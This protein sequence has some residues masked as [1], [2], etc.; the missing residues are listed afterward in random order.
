MW[1]Q[2][3]IAL[4]CITR[5]RALE[6]CT[7]HGAPEQRLVQF[8]YFLGRAGSGSVAEQDCNS[9]ADKKF[10]SKSWPSSS[11][12]PSKTLDILLRACPNLERP[13]SSLSLLDMEVLCVMGELVDGSRCH[14]S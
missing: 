9:I 11:F 6:I 4:G 13:P 3:T 5:H 7:N 1:R 2:C 10:I 8:K 14:S 12:P